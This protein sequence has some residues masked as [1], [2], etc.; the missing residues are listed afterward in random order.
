MESLLTDDELAAK[1]K[2]SK[3]TLWQ[4][5]REGLPH[6]MV[7]GVLRYDESEAIAW[8]RRDTVSKKETEHGLHE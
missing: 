7:R 4:L 5:R 1:W 2:V 6:V 8:L 3:S